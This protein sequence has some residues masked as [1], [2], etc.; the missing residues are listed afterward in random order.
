VTREREA[1]NVHT[2]G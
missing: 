1:I 2:V